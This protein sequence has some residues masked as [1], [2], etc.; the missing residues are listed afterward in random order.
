MGREDKCLVGS[1]VV[2]F[3]LPLFVATICISA[4]STPVAVPVKINNTI[5]KTNCLNS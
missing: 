5:L 2:V 3:L 1:T 4:H